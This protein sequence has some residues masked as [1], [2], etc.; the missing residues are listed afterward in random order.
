MVLE[1]FDNVVALELLLEPRRL[2]RF[3]CLRLPIV[4]VNK[5]EGLRV[6]VLP[7]SIGRFAPEINHGILGEISVSINIAHVGEVHYV[8]VAFDEIA[9]DAQ[10]LL[11]HASL[12]DGA[13]LPRQFSL[14][15]V[16]HG[17]GVL[18]GVRVALPQILERTRSLR[19]DQAVAI[20]DDYLEP[21]LRLRGAYLAVQTCTRVH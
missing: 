9:F 3:I 6:R 4:V 19:V 1:R 5:V 21:A 2:L 13:L 10:S 17:L 16:H 14:L 8:L 12:L 11:L 15:S 18:H 20:V 7:H